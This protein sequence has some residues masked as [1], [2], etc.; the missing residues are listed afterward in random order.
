VQK[1]TGARSVIDLGGTWQFMPGRGESAKEPAG[2]WG[3]IRVPGSWH[4]AVSARGRGGAWK[5]FDGKQTNKGWYRRAAEIPA[6]WRGRRVVL[7]LDRVSTDAMVVV[8]GEQA[9]QVHWPAGEVDVTD[10][11]KFGETNRITIMVLALNDREKVTQFMGYVN[12]PTAEAKLDSRGLI[13]DVNLLARPGPAHIRGAL[14]RTSVRRKKLYLDVEL[15]G[16]AKAGRVAFTARML[17]ESGREERRFAASAAVEAAGL[18][19]VTAAFDWPDPRLWDYKQPNLYT[20]ELAAEGAGL[21]DEIRQR[22][23]FREFWIEGREFFLNG[24]KIRLRPGTVGRGGPA[25]L[26]KRGLNFAHHWP[27]DQVR[28]G[29]RSDYDL[30]GIEQADRLGMLCDANVAHMKWYV[31][32]WDQPGVREECE[33]IIDHQ[34]RKYRNHPSVVMYTHTA[35]A[36]GWWGDGDPWD[37]GMTDMAATQE[38]VN[39]NRRV[40]KII[41]LIKRIDP[42]PVYAHHGSYNGDVYTS[43]L[44][45]NFLPLQEREEWLSHWTEHGDLPYMVVEFGPP[46]YASVMRGRA[47]YAHQGKSEPLPTEWAA[48]YFGRGAYKMES[49]EF[50]ALL[51]ERFQGGDLQQEYRPHIRHGDRQEIIIH[52]TGFREILALFISN[53]WR[54]WRTMGI[55]GGMVAWY[56]HTHPA[57]ARV[58]RESLAWIAGP[59]GVPDRKVAPE[60]TFSE[61]THH[62]TPGKAVRKQ[63]ALINDFRRPASFTAEWEASLNGRKLA[64]GTLTGELAVSE[65]RLVPVEFTLPAELDADKTRGTITLTAT[66]GGQK[67]EDA[68][69]FDVLAPPARAKR[70]LSVF[71]PEGATRKYL[72]SCG[73]EVEPWT[74]GEPARRV[75]VVGRNALSDGGQIPGDLRNWVARGGRLLVMGQDAA[76]T[77]H[78]LHLRTAPHQARRV[79]RIDGDRAITAGLDDRN[80]KNWNGSSTAAAG[81]PR[82]PGWD[83]SPRFGWHWGN[84]HTVSSTPI[85]KPH[86]S[87]WRPVLECEFDLAYTPLMEMDYGSG[88]VTFCTLDVE[89]RTA[90]DPA[91]DRLFAQ[92]LR[93]VAEAPLPG[94]AETVIYLG[95][96]AGRKTLDLLG[97]EYQPADKLAP[98]AD[99]VILGPGAEAPDADLRAYVEGGGK[100]LVL[101][102]EGEHAPLGVKLAKRAGFHGSTEVPDWPEAAGLSASDLRWR[103]AWDAWL[104]RP[105]KGVGVAAGGQLA[106]RV[107]GEG[108]VIYAQVDPGA[109]PADTKRYFRFTRWRQ[110]RA[111]SQLL[112]NLGATFAQDRAMLALLKEPDAYVNLAGHD[113]QAALVTPV[114]ESPERQW[115]AFRPITDR[116]RRLV[117]PGAPADAFQDVWAPAYM[118]AYGPAWR[119]TDGE[120]VFRKTIDW[121]AYAAG[122]PAFISVG[123]VDENEITFVNGRKVG[124]SRHWLFPRGHR[125]P[126]GLLTE[127]EN[128][129]AIRVWDEGIHGGLA[130]DPSD[131][132]VRAV[133]EDPGFYHSDYLSDDVPSG[134]RE[135]DWQ[136]RHEQRKIADN[137]YRYY[138]W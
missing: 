70:A 67:H 90:A 44:Y 33:R 97:V 47:G 69:V 4:D 26:L 93:H 41:G 124:S 87:G 112:A 22:F 89:G 15:A 29:V 24:T 10:A 110:T 126:E 12:E 88:R 48:V 19:K 56:H 125:I 135:S 34:V 98:A 31:K 39:T 83:W 91:A 123:R 137:P 45:L 37:I 18:Q 111:L 116:A 100:A 1:L 133:G 65:V 73:Y 129:I 118:E 14:V 30:P 86:R 6:G 72:A 76:W 54:S 11:V 109:I 7:Q 57:L 21:E 38:Y 62:F 20:M 42:K 78:A 59:G 53:T 71:D 95:G 115:N 117:E 85:E 55:S 96:D 134:T 136:Q 23:G 13:G 32:R 92:L 40:R 17:D 99:L 61:K 35:N 75:A 68:F 94:K 79:Y 105:G 127:G 74:R 102:R 113:W 16:I 28:R 60:R 5:G 50:R 131:L 104:V 107:I 3:K 120:A 49:P 46:L 58:N 27:R 103:A 64:D 128:T 36:L 106:R 81:Y 84:R 80:L 8:S 51:K 130:A 2:D 82:Y 9:G 119:W 114:R 101:R 108:V 77:Q 138:R 122:K 43:N 66:I 52:K 132:Y 25:A 63:I 121:P